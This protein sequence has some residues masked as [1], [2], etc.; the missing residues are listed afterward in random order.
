MGEGARATKQEEKLATLDKSPYS[1]MRRAVLWRFQD[2]RLESS[3]LWGIKKSPCQIKWRTNVI[4]GI[5]HFHL[6][7][8]VSHVLNQALKKSQQSGCLLEMKAKSKSM[9]SLQ[10]THSLPFQL[11]FPLLWELSS[12]SPASM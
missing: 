4:L 9:W 2:K 7:S 3:L 1:Q 11:A 8:H 6:L 10:H 12:S 5:E